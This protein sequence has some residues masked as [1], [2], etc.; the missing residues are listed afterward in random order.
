M[1]ETS[2]MGSARTFSPEE[3]TAMLFTKLKDTAEEALNTKVK[4]VV[5]GCPC[6]FTDR[7]RRGLL[8]AASI[9]GNN[10]SP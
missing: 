5:I 3:I 7:E 2:F 4:D 8:D 10:L 1:I 9:A 6:Y